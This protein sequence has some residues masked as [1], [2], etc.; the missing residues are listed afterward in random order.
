[1][2]GGG[3]GGGGGRFT[4]VVG[5]SVSVWQSCVSS[6][7]ARVDDD[8]DD[9]DGTDESGIA[10]VPVRDGGADHGDEKSALACLVCR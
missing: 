10:R 1:M 5:R 7:S 2:G 4:I 9:D 8:D 6:A 3:G